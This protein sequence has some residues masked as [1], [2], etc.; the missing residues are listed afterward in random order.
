[1]GYVIIALVY[2]VIMLKYKHVFIGIIIP[3]AVLTIV[4]RIKFIFSLHPQAFYTLNELMSMNH[5]L[6]TE[7]I[8][9]V[10]YDL[11]YILG[12]LII[13]IALY[14]VGLYIFKNK[15]IYWG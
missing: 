6:Y 8:H 9:I 12:F 7:R 11:F 10:P 14:S 2:H 1:M 4:D 15:D 3:M 5:V 13:I